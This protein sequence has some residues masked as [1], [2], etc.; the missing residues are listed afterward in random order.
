MQDTTKQFWNSYAVGESE[1]YGYYVFFLPNVDVDI[2]LL[3]TFYTG[4]DQLIGV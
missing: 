2:G 4:N 3:R 1:F